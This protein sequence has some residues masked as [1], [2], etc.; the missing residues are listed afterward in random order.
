[1]KYQGLTDEEVIKSKEK[2]GTNKIISHKKNSFIKLFLESLGDPIIKILI[3]ALCIKL[4]FLF[5]EI[6]YFETIG[7]IVSILIATIVSTIS[8]YGSEAA[9]QKLEEESSK[10]KVNVIRNNKNKTISIDDIVIG[11][12]VTLNMGDKV[13]ADGQIIDGEVY[14]NMSAINGESTLQKKTVNDRIFRGTTIEDGFC[15]LKVTKIGDMTMYG[16][17]FKEL[18]EK[19]LPSPLKTRLIKVAKIISKFGYIGAFLV[20]FSFLFSKIIILNN[21][22]IDLI[23]SDILNIK[24]LFSYLIEALT[25]AVTIIVVSVPEGLPLMITLVL[26]SNMKRMLKSNVLVRKLVGIETAGNITYLLSDKTGTITKGKLKVSYL[27]DGNLQVISSLK[28]LNNNYKDSLIN[29][30]YYNNTSKYDENKKAIGSNSTDRAILEFIVEEI[31]SKYSIVEQKPFNSNNKYSSVTLNNQITYFKGAPEIILNNCLKKIDENNNE[32]FIKDKNAILSKI[33]IYTKEGYRVIALAK[34]NEK[35]LVN[36][37]FLGLVLIRDE[38]R[39]EALPSINKLKNAGIKTIMITGDDLNTAINIAKEVNIITSNKD[40]VL[41]SQELHLLNDDKLSKIYPNI[42]IIARALPEDKSR[43]VKILQTNNE[44]V[45]MTGDG[46][47]DSPALKRSNVGFAMGSGTEVA[48]Q[49]SDII[50]LDDNIKSITEAVL[51]G[52]TIFKNIR[53]FIVFQ[54]SLNICAV[55]ISAIG[56]F[57]GIESPI[58]IVQM[59]WIN[60]IMDTLAG[61]AFSYEPALDEYLE[62]MPINKKTP[63]INDYMKNEIFFSGIYQALICILFLKVPLFNSFIRKDTSNKYLMTA[64]FTLFVFMGIFNTLNV[65]TPRINVLANLKRNIPFIA[66]LSFIIIFQIII[67]YKGGYIFRTYGLNIKELLYIVFISSSIIPIDII[68]KIIIKRKGKFD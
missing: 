64:Y 28:N 22:Q 1:M 24:L 25:I 36:M 60:M 58:T 16:N 34:S 54:L 52:R 8:E 38:V 50:I 68:R 23:I 31:P 56:P 6:N 46:V 30:M 39:K 67:I 41:T 45:G 35:S 7:I 11:D 21:F 5:R 61:I 4:I 48:K 42:K 29:S 14:L 53:K 55:F 32:L 3:V 49:A 10:I 44:I 47:N 33:K 51:Y 65:R 66:I 37:T 43:L 2:Y 20:A 12:I 15:T 40:I 13:P 63:I 62:E 19:N 9:F 27:L 18:Q 59:L 57:I 17:I 26:S